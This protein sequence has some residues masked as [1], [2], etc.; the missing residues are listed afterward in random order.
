MRRQFVL[1]RKTNRLLQQ[2]AA[3]GSA[4]YSAVVREAIQAYA[5]REAELETIEA[6]SGFIRMMAE[7]DRAIREGRVTSQDKVEKM[8]R[9]PK[10]RKKK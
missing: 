7:S 10:K 5:E 4:N 9:A 1:D 8:S 3:E 2:L 6:D